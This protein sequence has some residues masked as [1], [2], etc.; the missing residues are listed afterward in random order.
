MVGQDKN[1]SSIFPHFWVV[2]LIFLIFFLYILSFHLWVGGSVLEKRKV[3]FFFKTS[4]NGFLDLKNTHESFS[5]VK[6]CKTQ[7]ITFLNLKHDPFLPLHSPYLLLVQI[8]QITSYLNITEPQNIKLLDL[9][10]MGQVMLC[11]CA[12]NLPKM[13]QF[14]INVTVVSPVQICKQLRSH[15]L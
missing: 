10:M 12:T 2:S 4:K 3:L 11:Y 7:I 14:T 8:L 13:R 5:F 15:S 9:L 6:W 1:I